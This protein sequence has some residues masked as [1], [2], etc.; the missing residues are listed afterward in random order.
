MNENQKESAGDS[1][2]I[3]MEKYEFLGPWWLILIA[4]IVTLAF[5]AIILIW[6][7]MTVS[8]LVVFFAVLSIVFGIAGLIRSFTLIK[9]QKTWWVLLIEGILSIAVGIMVLVWPFSSV[10]V[11]I[12]FIGAWLLVTGITATATG[13][14]AKNSMVIVYGVL[15][16]I[17]GIFIL[18]RPPF[19]AATTLIFFVG[20]FAIFR[21][22]GMIT[23]SITMKVISSRQNKEIATS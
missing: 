7:F 20:F 16:I 3:T 9:K 8:F 5:G 19:Y 10:I 23:N 22:I 21:G 2:A 18:F 12:Y 4:G 15:S 13:S 1:V 6:P 17:L 14:T 11:L